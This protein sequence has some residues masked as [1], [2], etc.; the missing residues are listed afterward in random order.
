MYSFKA[1][2]YFVIAAISMWEIKH[3]TTKKTGHKS[4]KH[5]VKYEQLVL[6]NRCY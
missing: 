4:S 5:N 6:C 3:E 2:Q 1:H